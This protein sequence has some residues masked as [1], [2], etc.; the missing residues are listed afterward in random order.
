MRIKNGFILRKVGKEYMAV[1]VGDAAKDFNGMIRMNEAGAWLWNQMKEEVSEEEMVERMCAYYEELSP[2]Q[3]K[4]D[5]GEFL[6]SIHVA[7]EE[8]SGYPH[9]VV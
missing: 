8:I 7:V 2:E 3:A 1:A 5:L 6:K 4:A 9:H